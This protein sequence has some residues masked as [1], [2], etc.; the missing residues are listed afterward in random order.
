MKK[1]DS[2]KLKAFRYHIY[3]NKEQRTFFAKTFGC[4][5]LVYN[6]MLSEKIEALKN[7]QPLPTI[8]P[9]KYKEEFPFLK[10]VDSLALMNAQR[11][12]DSAFKNF[13]KNP[14]H[15][16]FPKFKRKRD[17]QSYTTNN[18]NNNIKID[19]KNGL[20]YL[21]KIKDGI[22]IE[23]HREFN[24]RIVS[25]SI[26]RTPSGNYY[27]SILV[28]LEDESGRRNKTKQSKNKVCGIDLGLKEFAT[29]TDDSGTYKI[30]HPKYL[31]KAEKRLKKLQR[32]F[33]RKQ[34]GSKN[35]EKAR[36]K[37]AKQHEYVANLRNDF[38]HKLSKAIIDDNQV[39][40][41]EDLNVKGMLKNEYLSKS[42]SD[43]GF[44]KFLNYLEYK[45]DWYGRTLI[46]VDRFYP[47]SKLCNVCGYKH[48]QLK[49]SD[50]YWTCPV[51]RTYHDRDINAS[52]NLYK[53]GLERPEF[54]PVEHALVDD[55]ISKGIPK[56]PS[57]C[58]AGSPAFYK[59][60]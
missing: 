18:V 38:L 2:K 30:E 10:E 31:R 46:V 15:Y 25:V 44:G 41:V 59:A 48:K 4:V 8:T 50:R 27:A 6:K 42:I 57:C 16:R 12:L 32:A 23:K 39:I 58:E 47:S 22:E 54:K 13:F 20:L 5:R 52:I 51:C 21:P 49:L 43:S 33:D 11:N 1:L 19:F 55:R 3:P 40:V 45:A 60:G 17:K 14:Q 26:S 37:L 34:K 7:K 9:A 56:K 35:K 36:I 53:V 24:G 29:I 28:E